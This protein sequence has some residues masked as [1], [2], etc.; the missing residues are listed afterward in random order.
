MALIPQA[1]VAIGLVLVVQDDA[2]L[3]DVSGL[4][5]AV[6][7]TAVCRRRH[8]ASSTR[9]NV[10]ASRRQHTVTSDVIEPSTSDR[11]PLLGSVDEQANA[12]GSP[13]YAGY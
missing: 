5:L 9:H 2:A 10:S 1:G 6:G 8:H 7:I 11:N 4:F 3:A 12:A 13:V